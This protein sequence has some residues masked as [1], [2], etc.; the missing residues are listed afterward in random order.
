MGT[1][2]NIPEKGTTPKG[3]NYDLKKEDWFETRVNTPTLD[4]HVLKDLYGKEGFSDFKSEDS[5]WKNKDIQDKFKKEFGKDA[6]KQFKEMYN[7]FKVEFAAFQMDIFKDKVDSFEVFRDD[8]DSLSA[9]VDL[10]FH[11]SGKEIQQGNRWSDPIRDVREASQEWIRIDKLNSNG[12]IET[13]TIPYSIDAY[14]RLDED[15]AFNGLAYSDNMRTVG[16]RTPT[17][18]LLQ[19]Q[20][21]YNG[22]IYDHKTKKFIRVR[23]DQVVSRWD[24]DTGNLF[25]GVFKN[26]KLKPK[27][28]LD[29]IK[30]LGRAP[31]DMAT[32]MLDTVIQLSRAGMAVGFG[33][34]NL[35]RAASGMTELSIN[36]DDMYKWLTAKGIGTK[37]SLTSKSRSALNG[38]F[39]GSLEMT[40]STIAD[41]GL[42]VGLARALSNVSLKVTG[43][44]GKHLAP[45]ELAKVQARYAGLTVKTTLTTMASKDSYNR[46]LDT[47]FT[48][49]ES[50]LITAAMTIGLWQATK[51]AEK[52]IIGNF[53]A[54]KVRGKIANSLTNDLKK[55][56]DSAGYKIIQGSNKQKDKLAFSEKALNMVDNLLKKIFKSDDIKI[57]NNKWAYAA[58]QEAIEEM[59]EELYQDIV[60]HGAS[61]YGSRVY[62]NAK[63]GKGRYLTIFDIGYGK[64]AFE[65]YATSGI[66]GGMGGPMGMIGQRGNV[67]SLTSTSSIVEIIADGETTTLV[68]VLKDLKESGALA[69][70]QLSKE[71]NESLQIF[72]PLIS[73]KGD[74]SLSDAVYKTLLQDIHVIDTFLSSGVFGDAKARVFSDVDFKESIEGTSMT[75]D[76][77]STSGRMIDI[78]SKTNISGKVYAELDALTEEQL[79][80]KL[81]NPNFKIAKVSTQ[82]EKNKI[83]RDS[84]KEISGEVNPADAIEEIKEEA[85]EEGKQEGKQEA[86]EAAAE[87]TT[88]EKEGTTALTPTTDDGTMGTRLEREV[89]VS[90][91]AVIADVEELLEGYR[92]IRSMSNGT[93]AEYYLM[94]NKIIDNE[95]F[96]GMKYRSEDMKH[97]G[98][99]PFVDHMMA[100]RSR[101]L[102]D[103]KNNEFKKVASL[104]LEQKIL[105]ITSITAESVAQLRAALDTS[106]AVMSKASIDH[107]LKL[108]ETMDLT[109]ISEALHPN[110]DGFIFENN[111]AAMKDAFFELLKAD[112][113]NLSGMFEDVDVDLFQE[114]TNTHIDFFIEAA[115]KGVENMNVPVMEDSGDGMDPTTMFSAYPGTLAMLETARSMNAETE[116]GKILKKHLSA[117]S[118]DYMGMR[119]LIKAASKLTTF[120]TPGEFDRKSLGPMFNMAKKTQY[121]PMLSG[122]STSD[123][124]FS[125][126]NMLIESSRD[127]DTAFTLKDST[128]VDDILSQLKIKKEFSKIISSFL[129]GGDRVGTGMHMAKMLSLFRKNVVSILKNEYEPGA[130]IDT[131][132][133]KHAYKDMSAFS[134]LFVDYFYDPI[135]LDEMFSMDSA[136]WGES[137]KKAYAAAISKQ[138]TFLTSVLDKETFS[139]DKFIRLDMEAV[140]VF[141][142][143][144]FEQYGKVNQLE[145]AVEQL[146]ADV[147]QLPNAVLGLPGEGMSFISMEGQ[148]RLNMIEGLLLATKAHIKAATDVTT[149]DVFIQEKEKSIRDTYIVFSKMIEDDDLKDLG[150]L[151]SEEVPEYA[152]FLSDG[153]KFGNTASYIKAGKLNIKI[154]SMLYSLYQ[155]DID[156][157]KYAVDNAETLAKID[158]YLHKLLKSTRES[159]LNPVPKDFINILGALTTDFTPFYSHFKTYLEN[160]NTDK[161]NIVMA[162]QEEAAKYIAASMYSNDFLDKFTNMVKELPGYSKNNVD[163]YIKAVYASGVAGSGKT[164][165]VTDLGISIAAK[166]LKNDGE[167]AKV[168]AVSNNDFQVKRLQDSLGDAAFDGLDVGGILKL[169]TDAVLSNDPAVSEAAIE[170]LDALSAVLIDEV[171][172]IEYDN[173]NVVNPRTGDIN[174]IAG[175]IDTYNTRHRVGKNKLTLVIMGDTAQMGKYRSYSS[176]YERADTPK[177]RALSLPY[178]QFSFRSRNSYMVDSLKAIRL[179][180]PSLGMDGGSSSTSVEMVPGMKYGITD[181]TYHG[182]KF[183]QST[184]NNGSEFTAEMND[185]TFVSNIK[186]KMDSDSKF[187]I[188][189]APENV[190]TFFNADSLMLNLYNT[191]DKNG[192]SIYA[193]R[194][195]VR[196]A[197]SIGGSE[198]NYVVAEMPDVHDSDATKDL[199]YGNMVH[200]LFNTIATRAFDYAAVINKSPDVNVSDAAR[201]TREDGQAFLPSSKVEAQAKKDVK[202]LY[203]SILNDTVNVVPDTENDTVNDTVNDDGKGKKQEERKDGENGTVNFDDKLSED[204]KNEIDSVLENLDDFLNDGDAEVSSVDKDS[205][206]DILEMITDVHSPQ[207]DDDVRAQMLE[208]I[209]DKIKQ[210]EEETSKLL[211]LEEIVSLLDS[212][213]STESNELIRDMWAVRSGSFALDASIVMNDDDNT[214]SLGEVNL[215]FEGMDLNIR[216]FITRI[217]SAMEE[218]GSTRALEIYIESGMSDATMLQVYIDD[219]FESEQNRTTALALFSG[220]YSDSILSEEQ[221]DIIHRLI[222]DTLRFTIGT[223]TRALEKSTLPDILSNNPM[224]E[225]VRFFAYSASTEALSFSIKTMK[226]ATRIEVPRGTS[227]MLEMMLDAYSSDSVRIEVL[228]VLEEVLDKKGAVNALDTNAR[229]VS[230]LVSELRMIRAKEDIEFINDIIKVRDGAI[231]AILSGNSTTAHRTLFLAEKLLEISRALFREAHIKAVRAMSGGNTEGNFFFYY[232]RTTEK[233]SLSDYIKNAEAKNPDEVYTMDLRDT[234]MFNLPKNYEILDSKKKLEFLDFSKDKGKDIISNYSNVSLL[235]VAA[236]EGAIKSAVRGDRK[237]LLLVDGVPHIDIYIIVDGGP[238]GKKIAIAKIDTSV[239]G[240]RSAAAYK[241]TAATNIIAAFSNKFTH[242]G[243]VPGSTSTISLDMSPAEAL[244]ARAGKVEVAVKTEDAAIID[245]KSLDELVQVSGISITNNMYVMMDP[246]SMF[247]GE[248]YI[249]YSHDHKVDLDAEIIAKE[250]KDRGFLPQNNFVRSKGGGITST[251]GILPINTRIPFDKLVEVL[252]EPDNTIELGSYTSIMSLT[253]QKYFADVML[254]HAEGTVAKFGI[255]GASTEIK[256]TG[257]VHALAASMLENYNDVVETSRKDLEAAPKIRARVAKA[258]EAIQS[259]KDLKTTIGTLA[260]VHFKNEI[261][262]SPVD[263]SPVLMKTKG[264]RYVLNIVQLAKLLGGTKSTILD[265]I[266]TLSNITNFSV[267]PTII[268]SDRTGGGVAGRISTDFVKKLGKY[269]NV[270]VENV[271]HPMLVLKAIAAL[272]VQGRTGTVVDKKIDA[273]VITEITKIQ[274]FSDSV[275]D[276]T[277]TSAEASSISAIN[278]KINRI[279]N[280]LGLYSIELKNDF[281]ALITTLETSRDMLNGKLKAMAMLNTIDSFMHKNLADQSFFYEEAAFIQAE[282]AFLGNVI[283]KAGSMDAQ[284]FD[285]FMMTYK[286]ITDIGVLEDLLN[287]ADIDGFVEKV[288]ENYPDQAQKEYIRRMIKD[289]I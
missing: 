21:V 3:D 62:E 226:E 261:E 262:G 11:N 250:Y 121:G 244:R 38:G 1:E 165:A 140:N 14:K 276:G 63:V 216:D 51:H 72:E 274:T 202:K 111:E 125:A 103:E 75:A 270:P 28:T 144:H 148:T 281:P 254:S 50:G 163:T 89:S 282:K 204:E 283:A 159:D 116:G 64:H 280:I 209:E 110:S 175:A 10:Q 223:K 169:T 115:T 41:V 74:E 269:L 186:G 16:P 95:V 196:N 39:F 197:E 145:K 108:T 265:G 141:L 158:K 35:Y 123:A 131:Y 112:P 4:P 272:S 133:E 246:E 188:L 191:K 66:A 152:D 17:N 128:R 287:G 80:E 47:G 221:V 54:K 174:T 181:G 150:K 27:T 237:K 257:K 278:K 170:Q 15:Q 85:R 84:I 97:L 58:R 70:S 279:N 172:Y 275:M 195:I 67:S 5:Y 113:E 138:A 166:I 239:T 182:M 37:G 71:F 53:D 9:S 177:S 242:D 101:T 253:L 32:N 153:K 69:P 117:V 171:T 12:E 173:G 142:E 189:L 45:K 184:S 44:L 248:V 34:T 249:A 8:L 143:G 271:E 277:N 49:A 260:A 137:E 207:M 247:A 263:S 135:Q 201:S 243:A 105:G 23:N 61:F 234:D 40:M 255:P 224:L 199:A 286:G 130:A 232:N 86:A 218:S 52:Y 94:Q 179:S 161:D 132:R 200:T 210:L 129:P 124:A 208:E 233:Y 259:N 83:Q 82:I 155:G 136:L 79:H 96:G 119:K 24:I 20:A 198:A 264:N 18:G 126:V 245:G 206:S 240:T 60:E 151:I 68:D 65:R 231:D 104:E 229:A 215:D 220:E 183:K 227:P 193:D 267:T 180:A 157:K 59:T 26:N 149:S 98:N 107:I 77:I 236:H 118:E 42:Q 33:V 256:V 127:G 230:Y 238:N 31:I 81:T 93:A 102:K 205:F 6:E 87:G 190:D 88:T 288:F 164:S 284:L 99:N 57:L 55:M 225:E 168:M 109:S 241:K 252:A 22:E 162:P 160:I 146:K 46:A 212:D 134:D 29:Y 187:N 222:E 235:A 122:T 92:K 185:A 154:E 147:I 114:H 100:I 76:F 251:M 36:E 211:N 56:Y 258:I 139:H 285:K 194:I 273:D 268:A 213:L 217:I 73:E 167:A 48:T 43:A 13:E 203:L 289:C 219:A 228:K 19:L 214:M 156:T 266:T 91:G 192:D 106:M 176:G 7:L 78:H 120:F 25:D 178:M 90:E 30:I 2:E